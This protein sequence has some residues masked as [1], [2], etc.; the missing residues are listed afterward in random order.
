M[1]LNNQ[2][3]LTGESCGKI[4]FGRINIKSCSL[5]K[6]CHADCLPSIQVFQLIYCGYYNKTVFIIHVSCH[7]QKMSYMT[8]QLLLGRT[9]SRSNVCSKVYSVIKYDTKVNRYGSDGSGTPAVKRERSVVFNLH[10]YACT[11]TR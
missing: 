9:R 8:S 6:G 5:L 1:K 2:F 7:F 3:R 4:T 11:N 10:A